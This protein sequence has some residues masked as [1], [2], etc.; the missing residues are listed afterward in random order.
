MKFTK[1]TRIFVQTD[2]CGTTSINLKC[3]NGDFVAAAVLT[4]VVANA[5]YMAIYH[6]DNTE[7]AINRRQY[8][9]FFEKEEKN[10]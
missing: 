9:E 1:G 7:E 4:E 6:P 5:L 8:P 2:E 10:A 3:E